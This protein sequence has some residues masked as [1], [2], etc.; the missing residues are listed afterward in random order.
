M[1]ML[2]LGAGIGAGLWLVL[3]GLLPPRPSLADALTA[4]L[5]P[6][7][8]APA[9]PLVAADQAG[10]VSRAGRPAVGVLSALGLPRASVRRDLAILGRPP[11]QHLAEQAVF[12]VCGLITPTVLALILDVAGLQVP[13]PVPFWSG[14]AL[15][16][17][18]FFT[19]DL[20][21]RADAQARRAEFRH[22]LSAF[23]DL[24]VIAL[25]G[26]AGVE[27]ALDDAADV[28]TGWAADQ[29]RRTLAAAR[30]ARVPPWQLLA[31]L[32]EEL[33]VPELAELAASISLAGTE[34][35]KVRTSLAAKAGALRAHQLTDAE[36][37]AHA[38][39]ERM[40]LPVVILLAGFLAFIAFP[41]VAHVM[42]TL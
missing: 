41:A 40:S 33:D 36:A 16:V 30:L 5:R 2:L 21:I 12:A 32:G 27:A 17:V 14:I 11:E 20:G 9:P 6:P 26:G 29:I 38:A 3:V 34:G 28:G 42:S 31:R 7:P 39:T 24:V 1:T 4:A 13:L 8:P 19:P 10:W 22:T 35:A 18:G 25:A 23:L 15:A 37:G